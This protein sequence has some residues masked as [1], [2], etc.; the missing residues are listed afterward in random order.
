MARSK[1]GPRIE[2]GDELGKKPSPLH[3]GSLFRRRPEHF[4]APVCRTRRFRRISN[5]GL[6]W[7][8]AD[9]VSAFLDPPFDS[10]VGFR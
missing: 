7:R 2:F 6:P 4:R 8:S 5:V 10:C 9:S 3:S 1:F